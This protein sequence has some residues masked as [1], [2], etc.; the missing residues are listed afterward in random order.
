MSGSG[1]SGELTVNKDSESGLE[2]RLVNRQAPDNVKTGNGPVQ[3]MYVDYVKQDEDQAIPAEKRR[4]VT[5]G[6]TVSGVIR[7]QSR[8]AIGFTLF[9]DKAKSQPGP[10]RNIK[11]KVETEEDVGINKSSDGNVSANSDNEYG[12]FSYSS[13]HGTERDDYWRLI[14]YASN[15]VDE[16][17]D[18]DQLPNNTFTRWNIQSYFSTKP[19]APEDASISVYPT[20]YFV[21]CI[22]GLNPHL[23][24]EEDPDI[25]FLSERPNGSDGS[26][27]NFNV[28]LSTGMG[29][30]SAGPS[31]STE[32]SLS[33]TD[34]EYN[35]SYSEWTLNQNE[36][37]TDQE[38]NDGVYLTVDT[39]TDSPVKEFEWSVDWHWTYNG[40]SDGRDPNI[41]HVF[42]TATR[43]PELDVKEV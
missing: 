18:R 9:H 13:V 21:T 4:W 20:D 1:F 23:D 40:P 31:I 3:R 28:G 37:P 32:L 26:S 27:F 24:D 30:V 29:V 12:V 17:Y 6:R 34:F 22:P 2:K 5:Y 36:F 14:S 16:R 38:D 19:T 11:L 10:T 42:E 7:D 35:H 43:T 25:Q 15:K 41:T 8:D 33:N 39:S